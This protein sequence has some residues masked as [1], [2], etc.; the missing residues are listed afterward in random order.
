MTPRSIL[1]F[2]G[3]HHIMSNVPVVNNCIILVS[4]DVSATDIDALHKKRH[5]NSL[6]LQRP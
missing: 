4:S 5:A 2:S 6:Q 3:L 1:V